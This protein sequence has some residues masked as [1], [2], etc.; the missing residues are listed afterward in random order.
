MTYKQRKIEKHFLGKYEDG[1]RS[2]LWAKTGSQILAIWQCFVLLP[3]F[4]T[5]EASRVPGIA[6]ALWGCA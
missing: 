1:K 2:L 5:F 6:F 3:C 4:A